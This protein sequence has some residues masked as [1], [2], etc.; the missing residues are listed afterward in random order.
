M[1]DWLK[2][3]I[4]YEINIRHTCSYRIVDCVTNSEPGDIGTPIVAWILSCDCGSEK[5]H[6]NDAG[7]RQLNHGVPYDAV[8]GLGEYAHNRIV[9]GAK[10]G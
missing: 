5:I 1:F 8:A 10:K 7:I 6:I 2:K 4:E 9:G 3:K